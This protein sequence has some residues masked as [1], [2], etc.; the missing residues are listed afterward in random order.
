MH[1]SSSIIVKTLAGLEHIVAEELLQ[2]GAENTSILKRAVQCNYNKKL[3]YTINIESTLAL[4]ALVPVET[5]SASNADEL[6]QAAMHIEWENYLDA[7][8]TFAIDASIFSKY[9]THTQYTSLKLKDAICDRFRKVKN[10]RPN[11]QIDQPD[12]LFNLHI[13]EKEVTISLD[14]SGDSLHKRGYKQY[15]DIAP[16][17]EVLAA[18]LITLSNWNK[19]DIF[20]DGMCGSGTIAIEATLMAMHKAPNLDRSYFALKQWKDFDA[21]QWE[22]CIQTANAK[23]ASPKNKIIAIDNQ[24]KALIKAKKNIY[25][26]RLN[27][28]IDIQKKNFLKYIPPHQKGVCIINPPYGERM[29]EEQDIEQFYKKI[30]D[31]FKQN[32]PLYT[33]G[34][35]S[36]DLDALKKIG[37]K[38]NKKYDLLNGKLTCKYKLYEIY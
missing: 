1:K 11:V 8:Q 36:S 2:L 17:N 24:D 22:Q 16:I 26:A 10:T 20:V 27:D 32:F 33:C 15:Q 13:H 30:G 12:I 23:I 25:K 14:S 31:S 9:F 37:L 35:I 5:F 29:N 18:G 4:K 28:Y 3:L 38:P 7:N 19:E 34:I 21:N 6:Y